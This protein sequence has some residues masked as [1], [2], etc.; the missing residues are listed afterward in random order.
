MSFQEW[1]NELYGCCVDLYDIPEEDLVELEKQY[2]EE[3]L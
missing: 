1:I 3:V 2:E